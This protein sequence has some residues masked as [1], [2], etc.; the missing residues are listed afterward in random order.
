MQ[1]NTDLEID[2]NEDVQLL[3]LKEA[4]VILV[5]ASTTLDAAAAT[6]QSM[7]SILRDKDTLAEIFNPMIAPLERVK[8]AARD[9]ACSVRRIVDQ[10]TYAIKS[11]CEFLK[12]F[13]V[14]LSRQCIFLKYSFLQ[15]RAIMARN[16]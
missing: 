6:F 4:E 10:I 3:L 9:F 11:E 14:N 12:G 5:N 16:C 1:G 8:F 13:T 15:I 7:V 2:P